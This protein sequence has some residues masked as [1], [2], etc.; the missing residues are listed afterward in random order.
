MFGKDPTEEGK[1]EISHIFYI[2]IFQDGRTA[3]HEAASC[4]SYGVCTLLVDNSAN[5]NL[6]SAVSYIS[7]PTNCV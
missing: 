7:S 1:P 6:R 2:F 3:L 5:I 4:G